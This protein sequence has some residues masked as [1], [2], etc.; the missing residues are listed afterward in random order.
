MGDVGRPLG[1]PAPLG[2]RG[3]EISFRRSMSKGAGQ[4]NALSQAC[5]TSREAWSRRARRHGARGIIKPSVL[6]C[7]V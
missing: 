6:R 7:S 3:C 1:K 5:G 4:E 2:R